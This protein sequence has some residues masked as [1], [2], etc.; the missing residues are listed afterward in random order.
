MQFRSSTWEEIS[1]E[2]PWVTRQAFDLC[3]EGRDLK[4]RR[5]ETEDTTEYMRANK[6]VQK[7]PKKAKMTGKVLRAGN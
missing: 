6:K 7:A 3:G 4:N 2:K 1:H 5:Y